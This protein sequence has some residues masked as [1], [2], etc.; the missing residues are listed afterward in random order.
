MLTVARGI[1][2]ALIIVFASPASAAEPATLRVSVIPTSVLAP[3][4]AGIKYGYFKE[5]GLSI[6]L[7][8]TVGGAT[9]AAA[10]S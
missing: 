1:L 6:D 4:Y 5:E 10:R 3:L 9:S 7:A 8:P 2:C